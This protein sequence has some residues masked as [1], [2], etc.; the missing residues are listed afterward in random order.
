MQSI[1]GILF[2]PVGCLAEFPS[3]QF[4]EIAAH[5]FG[6]RKKA[7]QS[8]SR[9]YWHLLNL[10]ESANKKLDESERQL[11]EALEVQAVAAASAYEDVVPALSE[12]KAMGVKLFIASSLSNTAITNFLERNSLNEFFSAVWNRDNAGG[13]KAA[14]LQSAIG[15][16]S[17]KPEQVMFITDTVEGLKV[18]KTVGVQSILMMNDPDESRRLAMHDPAGGIVSLHELPDFIRLVAAENATRPSN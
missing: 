18:A 17:L 12:L 1:E 4:L 3:E 8:G 6:R 16:A 11:I 2:D 14:P 13:V 15:E 5:L 7:S 10:I 9:S